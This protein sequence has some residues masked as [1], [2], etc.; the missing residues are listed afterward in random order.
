[1]SL[2]RVKEVTDGVEP[3]GNAVMA[4]NLFILG[5]YFEKQ[6]WLKYSEDMVINMK[7]RIQAYPSSHAHWAQVVT[8]QVNGVTTVVSTG[9]QARKYAETLRRKNKP[10]TIFAAA[11]NESKLPIF[12]NRF[13]KD[14]SLIYICRGTVCDAPVDKPEYAGF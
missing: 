14:E 11:A 7:N 10:Y 4:E 13:K 9:S 8:M 6:E 2:V 1:L 5:L 12:N 3:S